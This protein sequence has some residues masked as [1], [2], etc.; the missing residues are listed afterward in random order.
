[1][2]FDVAN[3]RQPPRGDADV[4]PAEKEKVPEPTIVFAPSISTV[5][6]QLVLHL[7]L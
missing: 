7:R 1:M 4:E 2:E 3:D 5:C 6:C